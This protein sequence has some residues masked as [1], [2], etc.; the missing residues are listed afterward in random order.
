VFDVIP[1]QSVQALLVNGQTAYV[2]AEKQ[3]VKYDLKSETK[4]VSGLYNGAT[5][6]SLA[7]SGK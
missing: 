3:L 5:P 4:T 2:A 1:S 7:L 6:H